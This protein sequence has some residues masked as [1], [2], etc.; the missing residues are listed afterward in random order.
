MR[1]VSPALA[2]IEILEWQDG[3]TCQWDSESRPHAAHLHIVRND[4]DRVAVL[5]V[6]IG[7]CDLANGRNRNHRIELRFIRGGQGCIAHLRNQQLLAFESRLHAPRLHAQSRA[8]NLNL[9]GNLSDPSQQRW[10]LARIVLPQ[11]SR[12]PPE[13][14]WA[15]Q[16]LQLCC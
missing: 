12:D 1:A 16:R 11:H 10:P 15:Q 14:L 4:R 2:L 3:N 7:E 6:C 8:A 9:G 13:L 5:R